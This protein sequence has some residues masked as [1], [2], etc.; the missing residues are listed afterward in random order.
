[1]LSSANE[2]FP[3]KGFR[4]KANLATFILHKTNNVLNVSECANNV[5]M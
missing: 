1:M 5:L 4:K 2:L 3:K